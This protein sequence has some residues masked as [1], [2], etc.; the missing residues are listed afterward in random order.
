[1]KKNIAVMFGGISAEHEV[2]VITGLQVLEKIDYEK[3]EVRAVYLNKDGLFYYYPLLTHRSL[4]QKIK[5]IL[6]S[7]GRDK[8]GAYM[9]EDTW[10]GKKHHIDGAYLAFHGGNGEDGSIQGMMEVLGI[11][12]TSS[13]HEGSVIAMNKNLM[14]QVLR[15]KGIPCVKSVGVFAEEFKNDK[16]RVVKKILEGVG[17]PVIIKPAHLGSSIGINIAKDENSLIAN[18]SAAAL[19][20]NEI[21]VEKLLEEFTEYNVSVRK[22]NG[23]IEC[24]EIERPKKQDEILSFADKYEREGGKKQTGTQG[25]MAGLAREL[26]AKISEELGQKVYSLAKRVF[27]ECRLGGTARIDMLFENKS[28]ELFVNE[29][30][31]IP[32][33]VAFYLW[34]ASGIQFQEQ[35]T[36]SL[37]RA[38]EAKN[39]REAYRLEYETNIVEKFVNQ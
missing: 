4:F 8:D 2:S 34:E 18:L 39:E 7:F 33:S 28:G 29:I 15:E 24:S 10:R 38:F 9:Q 26:P 1:M 12:H 32:G 35:I 31:P 30:N 3:F 23:K 25:G 14:K 11:A 20:D 6:C 22:F 16:D 19:V 27:E 36:Q 17:I 21:L 5:P 37:E 13:D